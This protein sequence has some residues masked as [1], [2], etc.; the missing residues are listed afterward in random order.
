MTFDPILTPI[1][2]ADL[3]RMRKSWVYNAARIGELPHLG[4]SAA[5]CASAA[6]RSRGRKA[7][8]HRVCG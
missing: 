8:I 3:L 2:V 4:A 6:D 7:P 5:R 1:E